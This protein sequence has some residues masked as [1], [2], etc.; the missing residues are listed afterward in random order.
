MV[1]AG[2]MRRQHRSGWAV[3]TV[4][5]IACFCAVVL[6]ASPARDRVVRVAAEAGGPEEGLDDDCLF[7][8]TQLPLCWAQSAAWH[9]V[10]Q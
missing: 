4:A 2:M 3:A 7:I 10:E 6:I 5:A 1:E 9:S 8:A